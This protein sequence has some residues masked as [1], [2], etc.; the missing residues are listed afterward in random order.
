MPRCVKLNSVPQ[1]VVID[2]ERDLDD[3][4]SSLESKLALI[5]SAQNESMGVGDESEHELEQALQSTRTFR[6][7]LKDSVS[8]IPFGKGIVGKIAKSGGRILVH[9]VLDSDLLDF[10]MIC[11]GYYKTT[12]ILC[13]CIC[14]IQGEVLGVVEAINKKHSCFQTVRYQLQ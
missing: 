14:N 9:S 5:N 1:E 10:E 11:G 13:S 12:N 2:L 6:G 8:R 7:K 4:I 3:E